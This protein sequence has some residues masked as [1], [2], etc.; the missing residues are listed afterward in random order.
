[1]LRESRPQLD[2]IPVS[3]ATAR[4]VTRM[5]ELVVEAGTATQA[6]IPG[7]RVAGKT[8]TAQKVDP[9]TRRYS[10]RDRISSFVGYAPAEDPRVVIAVVIDRPRKARYGGIVAAPAFRRVTEWALESMGVAVTPHPPAFEAPEAID[11][12][13]V[14]PRFLPDPALPPDTMQVALQ[15]YAGGVPNLLGR[16]MRDAIVMLD[17][18]GYR[19]QIDGWGVAIDQDPPPGTEAPPGTAVRVRF[20]STLR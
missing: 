11:G 2:G 9:E 18:S 4:T 16:G 6:R 8:G 5:M 20:D 10:A 15:S 7:V 19:V 14:V 1:V 3:N 13:P 17:E 12:R